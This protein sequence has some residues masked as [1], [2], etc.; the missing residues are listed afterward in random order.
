LK[1]SISGK[2][3]NRPQ[4][5]ST[6]AK[7][8]PFENAYWEQNQKVLDTFMQME[9][10]KLEVEKSRLKMQKALLAAYLLYEGNWKKHEENR[11]M[12]DKAKT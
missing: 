8:R 9:K 3:I 10:D 5:G 12:E 4:R 1:D 7:L 2:Q 6:D 11:R